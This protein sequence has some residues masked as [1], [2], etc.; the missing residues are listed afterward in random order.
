MLF[1]WRMKSSIDFAESPN[2]V[3]TLFMDSFVSD[4][5][6][7][8]AFP[9][10]RIL[11]VAKPAAMAPPIPF[12]IDLNPP[13]FPSTEFSLEAASETSASSCRP[14]VRVI[15]LPNDITRSASASCRT[16]RSSRP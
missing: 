6:S 8:V 12:S 7:I 15:P 11:S 1:A 9:N 10:S 4:A 2:T 5:A 16:P 3:W 14:R 13:S